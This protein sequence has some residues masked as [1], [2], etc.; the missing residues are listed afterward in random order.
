MINANGSDYLRK[1]M[2]LSATENWQGQAQA[3]GG[4]S[5]DLGG[6]VQNWTLLF[7]SGAVGIQLS[8]HL[9]KNSKSLN[10]SVRLK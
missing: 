8:K 1:Q 2:D 10:L 4:S 7:T 3:H 5:R 6:V 9:L